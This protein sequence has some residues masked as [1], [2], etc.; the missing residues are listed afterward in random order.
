MKPTPENLI[1]R[2]VKDYLNY[3]GWYNFPIMQGLGSMPGVC[4]RIAI[5]DGQVLFIEIKAANG[6]LSDKQRRFKQSIQAAGG[7]YIVARGYED[8]EPYVEEGA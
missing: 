2:Q 4:D 6:R 8:L 5:K 1:K 7:V 3:R